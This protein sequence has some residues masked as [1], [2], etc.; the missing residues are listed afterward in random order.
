MRRRNY[1]LDLDGILDVIRRVRVLVGMCKIIH[2]LYIY[3]A[4]NSAYLP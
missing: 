3:L 1:K 4:S 2:L